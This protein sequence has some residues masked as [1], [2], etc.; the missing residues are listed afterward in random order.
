MNPET[1]IPPE[2]SNEE[3]IRE[4]FDRLIATVDAEIVNSRVRDERH[5]EIV[6]ALLKRLELQR[7]NLGQGLENVDPRCAFHC[8]KKL[9]GR[10]PDDTESTNDL[11]TLREIFPN[12]KD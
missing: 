3:K 8:L 9:T 2:Q 12:V 6:F 10:D 7:S 5:S 1:L 11:A 4:I